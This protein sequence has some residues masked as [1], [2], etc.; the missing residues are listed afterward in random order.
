MFVHA[1]DQP[2]IPPL[3]CPARFRTEIVYFMTPPG[4]RGAPA[5]LADGEYWID[6]ADARRWLDEQVVYVVSPLDAENQAEIELTE[7]HEAFL[8]WL[9]AGNVRRVRLA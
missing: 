7:Y 4:V 2:H 6:A 8:E 9:L 5:D 1:V 3:E